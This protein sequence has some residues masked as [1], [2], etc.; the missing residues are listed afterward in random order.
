MPFLLLCGVAP[1]LIQTVVLHICGHHRRI[2][3]LLPFVFMELFPFCIAALAFT[4]KSPDGILGWEF[5]IVLSGWMAGAI[6][7]GCVSAW[8][9]WF[10]T[11]KGK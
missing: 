9:L 5:T 6:L 7:I 3:C 4:T 10:L 2:L 8:L 11:N 1:F